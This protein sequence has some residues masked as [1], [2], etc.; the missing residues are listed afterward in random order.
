MKIIGIIPARFA[1]TRFEGKPLV[2]ID[3]KSMIQRTYEQAAKCT[4]LT[5]IWVATDDERIFNHVKN[6]GGNVIMTA[7]THP[8]GTDRIAEALRI[9][10][11]DVDAVIN[12]QGDEPFIQPAQ[13]EKVAAMLRQPHT[14]IATL[15]KQLNRNEDILN[16]NIVKV[17][18]DANGKAL[19]FSRSPI[20][21]MRG[22]DP[23]VWVTH[24]NFYKHIGLYGYQNSILFEITKLS[25]SRLEL[26]ESLEQLRWLEAGFS[27]QIGIT[28]LETIGIDTPEDLQKISC[29]T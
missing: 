14:Q 20:P 23:S 17:V 15:A 27:I 9:V 6:F 21:Y 2:E 19:Y 10:A 11:T 26:A 5:A 25:P 16:P 29:R 3:G 28:D 18:F 22:V 1:S 4:E 12:I 13:I 8:S 24:T 7:D